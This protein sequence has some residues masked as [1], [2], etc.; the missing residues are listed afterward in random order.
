MGSV[1]RLRAV[2]GVTLAV[3]GLAAVVVSSSSAPAAVAVRGVDLAPG[4]VEVIAVEVKGAVKHAK[5][6]RVIRLSLPATDQPAGVEILAEDR[7]TK[8]VGHVGHYLL[9]IEVLH[10]TSTNASTAPA[11]G[12]V[13]GAASLIAGFRSHFRKR[14][15][16]KV[17]VNGDI[18]GASLHSLSGF[19][20]RI[21]SLT[22][23]AALNKLD[24]PALL[25][26]GELGLSAG[27]LVQLRGLWRNTWGFLH[28]RRDTAV[29]L[30]NLYAP[31]EAEFPGM[32]TAPPQSASTTPTA[33]TTPTPG[34]KPTPAAPAPQVFGSTLASAP[35]AIALG[36]VDF[37]LWEPAQPISVS[38]V[39][40]TIAVR[41]YYA[42]GSCGTICQ[43]SLHFQD[44]RPTAGGAL[45]VIVSSAPFTLPS[46]LGTYSF[47]LNAF[48]F[49][50][51]AGDFIGLST[52]G[53]SWEV[54]APAAGG[55]VSQFT[56]YSQDMNGDVFSPNLMLPGDQVN[57]QVT[58]QPNS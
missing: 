13:N 54:L 28:K 12:T 24:R 52:I 22:G 31:Y 25:D 47:T 37:V 35:D 16:S 18:F 32:F 27:Q 30:A 39:V 48:K 46:T 19:A 14:G 33:P 57:M 49:R 4:L 41:G 11:G 29:G 8:V 26:G 43:T 7:R 55:E 51:Q 58:V 44:L 38:G 5:P 3:A 21:H 9:L 15:A 1:A 50:V 53:G 45:Q 36:N 20:R 17:V 40:T 42:G 56:G 10:P 23:G 6:P 2:S 34:H